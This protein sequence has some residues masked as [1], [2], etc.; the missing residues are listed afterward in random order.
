[1]RLFIIGESRFGASFFRA[2][3]S[4][5]HEVVGVATSSPQL[6][7]D[8]LIAAAKAAGVATHDCEPI[9]GGWAKPV[10]ASG[11]ELLALANVSRIVARTTLEACPKGAICYHPSL[12]PKYRGRNAVADALR[13]GERKTGVTVFWPDDGADTGPILLQLSC[14][15]AD[16]DTPMSLYHDKLAPVGV[17]CM[18]VAVAAVAAG[19]AP[20]IPQDSGSIR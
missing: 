6:N 17:Q 5:G 14:E 8:P 18:L 2:A 3:C 1:M 16:G 20:R 11:A 13:A 12:L 15:I 7:G 4:N 10:R 9:L 19:C